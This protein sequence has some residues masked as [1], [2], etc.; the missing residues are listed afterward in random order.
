MHGPNKGDSP[1]VE[2]PTNPQPSS[3]TRVV[4]DDQLKYVFVC[5]LHRSGTTLLARSLGELT[6]CTSFRATGVPMDEGQH[7]QNVYPEDSAYGGPG[8]FAFCAEAHLTED[9]PL[10]T[11]ANIHRLRRSWEAH[12]DTGKKIRL[13]KSPIHLLMTRFLQAAFPN[14]YFVIIKRHPVPVSLATQKWSRTP[15]RH[16]FNHWLTA[17]EIFQQDRSHLANVYELAYEDFVDNPQGQLKRIAEFVGM[18]FVS[19]PDVEVD[20]AKDTTYHALWGQMLHTSVLRAHYRRLASLYEARFAVHSYSLMAPIGGTKSKLWDGSILFRALDTSLYP[21][22]DGWCAS[23][24]FRFDRP[25]YRRVGSP[26]TAILEACNLK[27]PAKQL[28]MYLVGR[29]RPRR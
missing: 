15:L 22:L 11:R 4:T 5:G 29:V 6:D 23:W 16:L 20:G 17:Q 19:C 10:L 12:W 21:A 2:G 9:S 28:M 3:A 8:K 27:E 14:T 18:D 26:A 1:S 25:W 13:E 24:D 7:L